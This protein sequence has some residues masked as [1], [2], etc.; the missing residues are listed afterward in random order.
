MGW[1]WRRWR[2][3]GRRCRRYRGYE[4]H[5]HDGNHDGESERG[6]TAEPRECGPSYHR[7]TDQDILNHLL[8]CFFISMI[9]K[10]SRSLLLAVFWLGASCP[11]GASHLSAS[12]RATAELPTRPPARPQRD[13]RRAPAVQ[14]VSRW[15][16]DL[17]MPGM[18]C[19][20]VRAA[21]TYRLPRPRR[22]GRGALGAPSSLSEPTRS[23]RGAHPAAHPPR[24]STAADHPLPSR[25]AVSRHQ[26]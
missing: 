21:A 15:T 8:R 9:V 17:D 1:C 3:A 11:F 16:H 7:G 24:L 12:K 5:D 25:P 22:P 2:H 10:T 4:Q 13:A 19:G 26:S 20:G 14:H 18:W 6:C 23:A